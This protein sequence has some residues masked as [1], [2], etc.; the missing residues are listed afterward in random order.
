MAVYRGMDIGT[1]KPTPR[2]RSGVPVHLIDLVEPCED[3]T[4][5]EFQAAVN[6]ALRDIESRGKTALLVGG[7]GLY[8]RAALGDLQVPGR[9]PD[10]ARQ[11]ESEAVDLG[12]AVLHSRLRD[13][14]PVAASRIEPT[15]TRRIVRALEVTI[16]SGSRF[17]SFGP[18]LSVYAPSAVSQ[19]GIPYVAG[20]HDELIRRRFETLLQL[21]FLEEVK[22]LASSPAGM[23]RTARQAIGYRE[24][25]DHVEN[26][27]PFDQAVD[28]AVRRTRTFARRQWAWFRR[29]P[30]ITWLDPSSDLLPQ[31]LERW[32]AVARSEVPVGD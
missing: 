15:N 20:I 30:R 24:L 27:T 22:N 19:I 5:S 13:L 12:P 16:G 23:S 7:T 8:L 14:D 4:V 10:V 32:D 28:A 1:A 25:L 31:L 26:G 6:E 21:G 3:F 17:S 11:L 9:W 18:G 29:D 2:E